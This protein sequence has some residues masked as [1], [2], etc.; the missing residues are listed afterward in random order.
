MRDLKT[1][2]NFKSCPRTSLL[3]RSSAFLTR[4]ALTLIAGL[5]SS[6]D[7]TAADKSRALFTIVAPVSAKEAPEDAVTVDI[8]GRARGDSLASLGDRMDVD[9]SKAD[10]KLRLWKVSD[11]YNFESSINIGDINQSVLPTDEQGKI[12]KEAKSVTDR[13]F[14]RYYMPNREP[15]TIDL[16]CKKKECR[17]LWVKAP[18]EPLEFQS[19]HVE[20]NI[21]GMRGRS[22][23]AGYNLAFYQDDTAVELPKAE[24]FPARLSYFHQASPWPPTK[25]TTL[26]REEL[27]I[28]AIEDWTM[29]VNETTG[30]RRIREL[31]RML[32][33]KGSVNID[34]TNGEY[35]E[36]RELKE[37][38]VLW[39]LPEQILRVTAATKDTRILR[40]AF[41]KK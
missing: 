38:Q 5:A 15:V 14:I 28:G 24:G 16:S 25:R 1:A 20:I 39:L 30:Y 41:E 6:G 2:Y 29:N 11:T 22:W 34:I 13:P 7:S 32:L 10:L 4:A 19:F 8:G 3:Q 40:V 18:Y 21:R 27:Q 33:M 35:L 9:T 36:S 31:S 26:T 23:K 12:L 17:A 37:G